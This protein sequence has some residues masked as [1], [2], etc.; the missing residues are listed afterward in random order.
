[1]VPSSWKYTTGY[2]CVCIM[3]NR[4]TEDRTTSLRGCDRHSWDVQVT[5]GQGEAAQERPATFPQTFKSVL[6]KKF[7]CLYPNSQPLGFRAKMIA[8]LGF[9]ET[10][11]Q[12]IGAGMLLGVEYFP[13]MHMALGSF[14]NATKKGNFFFHFTHPGAPIDHQWASRQWKPCFCWLIFS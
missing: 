8:R 7:C 4:N 12:G 6:L 14:H 10:L 11:A 9:T 13:G 2:I 1:M 3:E 5:P